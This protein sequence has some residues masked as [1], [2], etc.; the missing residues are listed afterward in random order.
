MEIG[1]LAAAVGVSAP[2]LRKIE[3]GYS[4]RTSVKVY[5]ALRDALGLSPDDGV[6]IRGN[7]WGAAVGDLGDTVN[8][9][10]AA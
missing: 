2:H 6:F 3:L 7:P 10:D 4:P 9:G 5:R 8:A 1:E